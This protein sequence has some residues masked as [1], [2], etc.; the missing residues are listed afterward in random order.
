MQSNLA[1]NRK[2]NGNRPRER[3]ADSLVRDRPDHAYC[4]ALVMACCNVEKRKRAMQAG[5][6]MQS[7]ARRC[8][9]LRGAALQLRF[10]TDP[11]GC[12]SGLADSRLSQAQHQHQHQPPSLEE[13][14]RD[15]RPAPH[16]SSY[17][18]SPSS[19][20]SSSSSHIICL[21]F[22]YIQHAPALTRIRVG[23]QRARRQS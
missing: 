16:V 4:A 11:V 17:L 3:S 9:A 6:E 10:N 2:K 23:L 20:S 15:Q 22:P 21:F 18:F 8:A 14:Q 1:L 19:S 5:R 12:L 7:A 13:D